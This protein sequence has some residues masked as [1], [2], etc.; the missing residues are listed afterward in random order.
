VE[1]L[2]A[3]FTPAPS[4]SAVVRSA[5][6]SLCAQVRRRCALSSSRS[7]A[8]G[9][10]ILVP[11]FYLKSASSELD[12]E[13]EAMRA[14]DRQSLCSRITSLRSAAVAAALVW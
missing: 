1:S 3:A 2:V 8:A 6:L 4:S 10:L 7:C 11:E 12:K 9:G 5:P 14:A 13:Q